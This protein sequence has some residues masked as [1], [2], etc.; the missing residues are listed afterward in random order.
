MGYTRFRDLT[1]VKFDSDVKASGR[2][3]VTFDSRR[4][5]GEVERLTEKGRLATTPR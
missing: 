3:C 1:R 4:K 5:L 2:H